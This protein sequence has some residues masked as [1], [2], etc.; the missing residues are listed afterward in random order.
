VARVRERFL[1]SFRAG[2]RAIFA[3]SAV[4]VPLVLVLVTD[5]VFGATQVVLLVAA[6]DVLGMSRGGFGA[7]SAA[8]GAGS[9]AALLV[10]NRAARSRRALVVL[11]V[12][13]LAASLPLALVAIANGPPVAL[14]LVGILGLGTVITDVLALTT[15]Q[16]L[17][18]SDRLARVF[19]ILDSLLVGANVLGAA[20]S[21]WLVSVVGIRPTQKT[22]V[23]GVEALDASSIRDASAPRK[24]SAVEYSV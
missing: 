11:G 22:I 12:A 2:V 16:R 15:L 17:I 18:P 23:T 4:A 13:V 7:L 6:T 14:V 19:G 20:V 10:I 8:L 5:V 24:P 1:Q 3:T 9:L 21:A